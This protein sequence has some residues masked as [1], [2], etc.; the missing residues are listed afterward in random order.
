VAAHEAH[1]KAKATSIV[2]HYPGGTC[3]PLRATLA[4]KFPAGIPPFSQGRESTGHPPPWQ[5]AVAFGSPSDIVLEP[6]SLYFPRGRN[7]RPNRPGSAPLAH[8]RFCF[9]SS[10]RPLP[11]PSCADAS[12]SLLPVIRSCVAFVSLLVTT[13]SSSLVIYPWF[14]KSDRGEQHFE[15]CLHGETKCPQNPPSGIM[16]LGYLPFAPKSSLRRLG[17]PPRP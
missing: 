6:N 7:P 17:L 9:S 10:R 4:V 2:G 12:V 15:D 14:P 13:S 16:A 5:I 11:P 8:R 1:A 3:A